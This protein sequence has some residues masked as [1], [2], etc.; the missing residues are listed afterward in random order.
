VPQSGLHGRSPTH[1]VIRNK[2]VKMSVRY[3]R[4]EQVEQSDV[5]MEQQLG[6]KKMLEGGSYAMVLR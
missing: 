2:R 6:N 3:V 1:Y 4:V 5:D